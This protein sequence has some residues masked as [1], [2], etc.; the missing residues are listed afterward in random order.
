MILPENATLMLFFAKS[1]S[2]AYLSSLLPA[3]ER[4]FAAAWEFVACRRRSDDERAD[5]AGRG[6]FRSPEREFPARPL[7]RMGESRGRAD[8]RGIL[9][10]SARGRNSALGTRRRAGCIC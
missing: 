7:S 4:A 3:A 10:R 9:G 2:L 5:Q 8:R 1:Q 6:Q